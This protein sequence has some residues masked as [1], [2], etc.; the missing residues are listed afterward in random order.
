MKNKELFDRTI[1]ILVKA[2]MEG[3][4]LH[5]NE[6]ACVIGNM[7]AANNDI[8]IKTNPLAWSKDGEIIDDPDWNKVHNLGNMRSLAYLDSISL[9]RGKRELES[10]GYSVHETC[11]IEGVFERKYITVVDGGN[12]EDTDGYL[13]LM[14]VVDCLMEIHQCT[15][16][17][18]KEETKAMFVNE[19]VI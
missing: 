2:Y 10:T 15:D 13:G 3:V 19:V 8:C 18:V 17:K 14:A 5:G 16:E 1:S 12:Y 4:L 9:F 11:K 7:I 6:C